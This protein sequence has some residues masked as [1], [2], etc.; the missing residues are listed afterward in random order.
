MEN[1]L[2]QSQRSNLD[3]LETLFLE[4]HDFFNKK[5]NNYKEAVITNDQNLKQVIDDL[6]KFLEKSHSVVNGDKPMDHELLSLLT[7]YLKAK[8]NRSNTSVKVE[9]ENF[10]KRFDLA[11]QDSV[12]VLKSGVNFESTDPDKPKV[13]SSK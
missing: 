10:F 11:L 1:E 13:F 7:D 4:F 2:L 3:S 9:K 8:I 6:E 12:V 5:I